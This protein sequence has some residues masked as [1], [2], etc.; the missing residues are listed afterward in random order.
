MTAD[1]GP[2]TVLVC[3]ND[4]APVIAS[5]YRLTKGAIYVCEAVERCLLPCPWDQCGYIGVRVK[6]K[7]DAK[8]YL[9]CP[10]FFRPLNDGDTSLVE[11]EKYENKEII[12]RIPI[13]KPIK[14]LI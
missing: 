6:G 7:G 1:I 11:H 10:N 5:R 13:V 2:G 4:G 12:S 3:V 14:E 9:Y 8:K